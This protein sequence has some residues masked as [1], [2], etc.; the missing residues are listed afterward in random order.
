MKSLLI[1]LSIAI[2]VTTVIFLS[3]SNAVSQTHDGDILGSALNEVGFTRGD[4]GYE[5]RGYWNRFPVDV[6][7]R[8]PFFDDLFAEP[9]RLYDFSQVMANAAEIYLDPAFAD[10]T[11]IGLYKLT[12]H[13]GVDKRISGFRDYS[14]N[15][16][17]APTGDEPLL[18]AFRQ[19]WAA[20]GREAEYRTFGNRYGVTDQTS[21]LR[22]QTAPLPDA[23]QLVL[24]RLIV[25]LAD[26]IKW[27]QLAFRNCDRADMDK[28]LAIR[29]LA[30]T[31]GDGQVYYPELDDLAGDVDW[32]SLYYSALKTAAAVEQAERALLPLASTI[33]DDYELDINT[34]FGRFAVFSPVYERDKLPH[35]FFS[36]IRGRRPDWMWFDCSHTLCVIDFGRNAIWQGT[37]GAAV[38]SGNPVSVLIDLGGDDYYGYAESPDRPSAPSAGVGLL[39]VGMVLDSKGDDH[40][41]GTT[42]AQGVG[43]FGVGVVFD[44]EG[45]DSYKAAESAQGCGYFGI[46]LCLDGGGNDEYYLFGDGQGAGG[47]GGGVGVLASF[48]GNDKYIA[49]P[50]ATVFN[51]G[52][53]HSEQKINANN[54]QGGGFGRRGDGSDGHAWAGG[55]GALIDI[56]GD[57]RY[58]SGNF[59]LGIGY[60]FGTGIVIDRTGDDHYRS[61]YF[62]QGS[63]AHFC[64]GVLIDEAGDD[65]HELYETA[66]A[67]LAF[68]WDFTNALFVNRGGNDHYEAKMISFGLAQIR[69]NALFVEIGGN[70]EYVYRSGQQGFGAATWRADYAA[71]SRLTPYY[72]Y[73]KS[74][75]GFFDIGGTDSYVVRDSAETR[76]PHPIARDNHRWLIPAREDSTFGAQNFGVG[77]DAADGSIPELDL[78]HRE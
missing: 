54:A 23:V 40:Y 63:G 10:S 34:P 60:W 51:R 58:E 47:I 5:P 66:G 6:P 41:E 38:T 46:G 35:R 20:A 16:A 27:H 28:A 57:D 73:A 25:N 1:W 22:T 64:N 55:L 67:G 12:Y 18:E 31:Q 21:E 68:G 56:H 15:L 26:A 3:P 8:L 4:L 32:P 30:Q 43:L 45:D 61:C 74:F 75:G 9:L 7:Y 59:T 44:R 49:E 33:P 62:T 69:S 71:P 13:L 65:V 76:S 53:Y 29:D 72:Y 19:L 42:Y 70:D 50:D 24:A 11:D 77:I 52:D 78:W 2:S 36:S 17:E 14:A 48:S 39:G 37:P